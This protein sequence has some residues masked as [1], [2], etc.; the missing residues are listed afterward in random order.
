MKT[1][2][3]FLVVAVGLLTFAVTAP[4]Q[5]KKAAAPPTIASVMNTQLGI[6][7]HEFVGAAE[8]M[9]EDK[10]S[11]APTSGEFKGVRTF[12]QEV[13]HVATVNFAFYSAILGQTPPPGVSANEQMNGPDDI[14][15]KEQIVKYLKD[16]FA[17]GHKAFSTITVRNAMTP[18]PK[19]PISFLN[20]RLALASF[21]CTHAFD[22]YGQM[23]EYLR[24]NGI[25]PPASKGQGPA[26]PS[27]R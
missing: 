20:T 4:A 1:A 25:V 7:E 24:M 27:S 9:P 17:L 18:L 12:A 5:Q 13:K 2:A 22:H 8:A 10:Y 21:G 19:P 16:S 11:F 15:T 23:V 3:G 26:N 14:Q 6:V